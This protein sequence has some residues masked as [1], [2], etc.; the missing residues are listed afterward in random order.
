VFDLRSG[1]ERHAVRNQRDFILYECAE[2]LGG[3]GRVVSEKKIGCRRWW[4]K[5]SDNLP[6]LHILSRAPPKVMREIH[7]DHVARFAQGIVAA[8]AVERNLQRR[9]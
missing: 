5:N 2:K 7:L 6:P 3:S 9:V 8:I 1:N 4:R